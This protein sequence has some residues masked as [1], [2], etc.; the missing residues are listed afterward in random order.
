MSLVSFIQPCVHNIDLLIDENIFFPISLKK[1]KVNPVIC[2]NID[3]SIGHYAKWNKRD[4]KEKNTK[5]HIH[6]EY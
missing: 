6:G 3:Q 1:N 5:L 4:T 2:D